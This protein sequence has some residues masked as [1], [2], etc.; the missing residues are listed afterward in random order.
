MIFTVWQL[1]RPEDY[2]GTYGSTRRVFPLAYHEA[3]T[4]EADS[5]D[6]AFVAGQNDFAPNGT[7][8]PEHRCPS[9]SV[10]DVLV[11]PEGRA[12]EVA[13]IGWIARAY[14]GPPATF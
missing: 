11:D 7:W 14:S 4:I 1:K 12:W 5:L 3:G 9:V 10:G 6:T 13:P 2:V 8:N